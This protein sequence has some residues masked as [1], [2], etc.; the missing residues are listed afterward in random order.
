MRE[1]GKFLGIFAAAGFLLIGQFFVSDAYAYLD[2]SSGS[3]AIQAILGVLVGLGITIK[4]YY[5][6]IKY[7]LSSK[8]T[9]RKNSHKD[10]DSED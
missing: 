7:K 4:V 1:K 5:G 6:K 3:M 8:F 10:L 2:P 9:N